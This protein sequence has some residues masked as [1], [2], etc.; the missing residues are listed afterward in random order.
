M[1]LNYESGSQE[2][3]FDG[4]KGRQKI[5]WYYSLL[6]FHKY[7]NLIPMY[8]HCHKQK[9]MSVVGRLKIN[10][11]SDVNCAFIPRLLARMGISNT[12]LLQKIPPAIC[13]P[14]SHNFNLNIKIGIF[15]K[16]WKLGIL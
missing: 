3:Q 5:S 1:I 12:K 16:N 9:I 2:D 6:I 4:K 14:P 13:M 8:V 10:Q 7:S 11:E 15:W